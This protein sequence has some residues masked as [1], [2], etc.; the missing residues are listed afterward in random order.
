MNMFEYKDKTIAVIP[1]HPSK[2]DLEEL[3]REA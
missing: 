1:N 2:A 3:T